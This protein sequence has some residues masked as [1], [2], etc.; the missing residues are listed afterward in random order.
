MEQEPPERNW[1]VALNN[2][3]KPSMNSAGKMEDLSEEQRTWQKLFKPR[4]PLRIAG[5]ESRNVVM[6]IMGREEIVFKT[7]HA[8]Y[9]AQ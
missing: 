9:F 6:G 1:G 5:L 3:A 2:R 7:L 8:V 4:K